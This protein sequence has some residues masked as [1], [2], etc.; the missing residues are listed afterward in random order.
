MLS[1]IQLREVFHFCFLHRLLK[2]SDIDLYVLKGG[3]NLRFF[4]GSPR[5]SEDMDLDV[6]AGN[7]AT[8]KKN[9]YKILQDAAFLRSLRVFD[10]DAID[11]NDPAK[12]KH[13]ETTQ[14]FGCSLVRSSGVR[15]PTKV[16]F[17][18]RADDPGNAAASEPVDAAIALPYRKLA[19]RCRHYT[20]SAAIVQKIDAL[21]GRTVPQARDVFDLGIL[22][23]GGHLDTAVAEDLLKDAPVRQAIA[24]L[25]ELHWDDFNG[26]VVEYLDDDSRDAFNKRDH[27]V[28]LQNLVYES[29][30]KH[31]RT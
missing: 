30:E 14:R 26:Q 20:G 4:F 18:R 5:F 29:L 21:A 11:V 2:T 7:V 9:G 8:L 19:F 22:I 16:E 12:A 28:T 6:V 23:R 25:M 17:S 1:D 27:W 24:C 3:I 15:L 10:I 13:T 31:A